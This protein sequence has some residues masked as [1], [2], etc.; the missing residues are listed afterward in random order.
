M[1]LDRFEILQRAPYSAGRT[2]GT[3]G[4]FEQ[5]DGIAHFAVDPNHPANRKIVDLALAP[6]D[7]HGLVRFTSDLSIVLP[8][9]P[10]LGNGSAIVE[11]P[12]R[13]RRRVVPVL[14]LAPF[15]AP[16]TREAHPGD[17]FLFNRGFTV[18]SIAWQWDVCRTDAMMGLDAPLA[19]VDG[20]PVSGENMVEIR[21]G[22]RVDTWLLA[23]RA[24]KPLPAAPGPQI[25]AVLYVREYEDGEDDIVERNRWQFARRDDAGAL[26]ADPNY[27]H[28]EGGFDPGRIYQVVYQCNRAPVA[29]TGLLAIRDV[30]PFLRAVREDN[31]TGGNFKAIHAWGVSQTG[32]LQRDFLSLG[33]NRCEDG[34]TAYDGMQVHVAGARRGSFNHR[35]A[36]PSNQTTPVWGHAFPYA[37]SPIADALTQR[38]EGLLDALDVDGS[39][40]KIIY[41]DTAA[42]Y[43]RGDAALSHIH[44]DG[45]TDLPEHPMTRR[46]LFASTQHVAGYP[47]QS[48][49]NEAV[50]IVT[51]YPMNV[52]DYRP[53]LRAALVHLDA[54]VRKGLEPPPSMHPRV[55]DGTAVTRDEV[56]EYFS[57]LPGF[58]PPQ[59]DRLPFVRTVDMGGD[60]SAGI[61]RFPAREGDFYPALVSALDAN[62]NEVAG[63]RLP[64]VEEP[65]GTHAGWNPRDP[66]IGASEQ[67]VPMSGLTLGFCIDEAERKSADDPRPSLAER[68]LD[69]AD[70]EARAR[71]AAK[72]LAHSGYLLEEDIE[73]AT[74]A[75]TARYRAA[76]AKS[77]GPRRP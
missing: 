14:N 27:I 49:A 47:G 3:A 16:V 23:D 63:I 68:Y 44:T 25:D 73:I 26:R 31:P 46:Y 58:V 1:A 55:A 37:D 33:L 74:A 30:A 11:L 50:N 35:F 6:R 72:A 71:A 42:E 15:D 36:Q 64:D 51:R 38:S 56:L 32:R 34:S 4:A 10:D 76:V 17:G 70:Y 57:G 18:V 24:H 13:G 21:P 9:N 61:A 60:E 53:L 7:E 2:F 48:R 43:W 67:I 5:I 8:V 65:I 19:E 40:P 75:A 29:G 12:N 54:W 66:D 39:V 28:L 52:I 77:L 41:T 59:A 69:E 22:A 62:G 45:T 20:S